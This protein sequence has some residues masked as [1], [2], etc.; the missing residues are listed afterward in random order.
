MRLCYGGSFNPI[1]NGHL[2]VA[3]SVMETCGYEQV[4]LIPSRQPPHKPDDPALASPADRLTMCQL[5]VEHD[6]DFS[7]SDIELARTGP[8][9]T[10]DTVR[11]LRAQGWPQV[12]WLIGADMLAALPNWR[13]P[14]ALVR[15]A[16]LVIVA[17]PGWTFEWDRLPPYLQSLKGNVV[18]APLVPISASDIR[19]RVGSG[20]TVKGLVPLNVEMYILDRGLYTAHAS[21]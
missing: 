11:Q 2:T 21:G 16:H 15:E 7:I 3:R 6:S 17:R 12:H 20:Q 14:E 1:H 4:V 10:I 13:E 5:A 8:S 18:Q 19:R 9:Y